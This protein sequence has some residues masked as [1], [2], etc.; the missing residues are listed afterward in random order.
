MQRWNFAFT[1]E[2]EDDFK[3]LDRDIRIRVYKRLEWLVENFEELEPIPLTGAWQGF[4]K[5][6]IGDWRI[7]YKI[8]NEKSLIIV[9]VIDRRDKV[10][11][12]KP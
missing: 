6:R 11:K 8:E 7:I 12:R 3:K 4:F 1:S 5:L 9:Y 2:A 10:Y